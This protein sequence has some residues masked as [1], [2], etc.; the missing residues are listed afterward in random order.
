MQLPNAGS[1]L[2]DVC[3]AEQISCDLWSPPINY[4]TLG[5]GVE[6]KSIRVHPRPLPIGTNCLSGASKSLPISSP[7]ISHPSK[8]SSKAA[9]ANEHRVDKQTAAAAAALAQ[10][11]RRGSGSLQEQRAACLLLQSISSRCP[12]HFSP[13]TS[14]SIC[15]QKGPREQQRKQSE[16]SGRTDRVRER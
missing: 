16:A 8:A 12:L 2:V 6:E 7:S 3:R 5:F 1:Q 10:D 14:N 4:A 11:T 9:E 13:S 15:P